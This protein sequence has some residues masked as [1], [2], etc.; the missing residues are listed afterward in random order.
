MSDITP[1]FRRPPPKTLGPQKFRPANRPGHHNGLLA[2]AAGLN[3]S[4]HTPHGGRS[5]SGT[6]GGHAQFR[7]T[8]APQDQLFRSTATP[9]HSIEKLFA[10]PPFS[11]SGQCVERARLLKPGGEAPS[12]SRRPSISSSSVFALAAGVASRSSCYRSRARSHLKAW[13]RAEARRAGSEGAHG[14]APALVVRGNKSLARET[15]HSPT[16]G[17][18]ATT[19]QLPA[20]SWGWGTTERPKVARTELSSPAPAYRRSFR[21]MAYAALLSSSRG[22]TATGTRSSPKTAAIS[23]WPPSASM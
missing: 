6:D 19:P 20:P 13:D 12:S 14:R 16:P 11:R 7:R 9:P 8:A 21:P 15:Q 2:S 10:T 3:C 22:P 5:R 17:Q 1:G 23:R 4:Q 18:A